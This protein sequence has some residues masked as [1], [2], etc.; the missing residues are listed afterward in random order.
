MKHIEQ[1]WQAEYEWVCGIRSRNWQRWKH[2]SLAT[3]SS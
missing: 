1:N 3:T 2:C